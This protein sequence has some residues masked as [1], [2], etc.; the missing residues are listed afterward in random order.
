MEWHFSSEY[1]LARSALFYQV[2]N[3][4][5]K[6][7]SRRAHY[8]MAGVFRL[9]SPIDFEYQWMLALY[10]EKNRNKLNKKGV[11]IRF[12]CRNLCENLKNCNTFRNISMHTS[13]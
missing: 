1:T 5:H 13:T 11:F 12:V 2:R 3:A 10:E 4:V 6:W 7:K 9:Y 8:R